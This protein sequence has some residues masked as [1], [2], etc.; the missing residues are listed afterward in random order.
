MNYVTC[1]I[2]VNIINVHVYKYEP[3]YEKSGLIDDIKISLL[4]FSLWRNL[5]KKKSR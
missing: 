3:V 1:I 5:D 2:K 4:G